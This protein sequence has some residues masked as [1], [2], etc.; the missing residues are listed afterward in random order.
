MVSQKHGY[1]CYA[2]IHFILFKP[3]ATR[4]QCCNQY[5][6]H[7]FIHLILPIQHKKRELST[8]L[9]QTPL[10]QLC[11]NH[12][13][14]YV[15]PNSCYCTTLIFVLGGNTVSRVHEVYCKCQ[16][17]KIKTK[18]TQI[19]TYLSFPGLPSVPVAE[20]H[21][22]WHGSGLARPREP[23]RHAGQGQPQEG[24][25]SEQSDGQLP[26]SAQPAGGHASEERT[27]CCRCSQEQL[28]HS[29]RYSAPA[30]SVR[31]TAV[32]TGNKV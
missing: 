28:T 26:E 5:I 27:V 4:W 29:H 32:T 12:N 30:S 11:L 23:R 21:Q 22:R 25:P 20:L 18:H 15:S 2:V 3:L 1:H 17:E 7:Q 14:W 13:L 9:L 8:Y 19:N 6:C 31:K 24:E 16:N 10:K